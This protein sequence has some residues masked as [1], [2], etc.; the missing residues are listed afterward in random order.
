MALKI[1]PEMLIAD[2][3]IYIE[4]MDLSTAAFKLTA[5]HLHSM[6]L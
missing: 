2:E 4:K 6:R 3:Y 1:G 5:T